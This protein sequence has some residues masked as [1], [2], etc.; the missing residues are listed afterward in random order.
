MRLD[1]GAVSTLRDALENSQAAQVYAP[2]AAEVLLARTPAIAPEE[3][4]QLLEALLSISLLRASQDQS[5][6]AVSKSI[7]D[8]IEA[9]RGGDLRFGPK[10]RLVFET[11]LRSL[12]EVPLLALQAKANDLATEHERILHEAR[13][14]TDVRPVFGDDAERGP[15]GLI[16]S[17]MLKLSYI[18][19][20]EL[21][22]LFIAADEDSLGKLKEAIERA[23]LKQTSLTSVL[24]ALDIPKLSTSTS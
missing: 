6:E 4:E 11:Q 8:A 17:H 22:D 14:L 18:A 10:D 7:G 15:T 13:I 12:L 3:L 23:Q 2:A 1:E 19:G 20:G 16:I 5:A 21:Q 9:K 24:E